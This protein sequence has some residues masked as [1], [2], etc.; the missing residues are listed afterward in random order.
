MHTNQI[1]R[2]AKGGAHKPHQLNEYNF[3]NTKLLQTKKKEE[4]VTHQN[5]HSEYALRNTTQ[6]DFI[7]V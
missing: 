6:E 5:T 3:K 1:I 7:F 4:Y 2:L